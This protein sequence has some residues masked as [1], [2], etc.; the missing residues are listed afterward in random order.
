MLG[1]GAR[2][3]RPGGGAPGVTAPGAVS[4][5]P[6]IACGV[7]SAWMPLGAEQDA[8]AAGLGATGMAPSAELAALGVPAVP[9]TGFGALGI[10]AAPGSELAVPGAPGT[11]LGALV[12]GLPG[13]GDRLEG[14]AAPSPTSGSVGIPGAGAGIPAGLTNASRCPLVNLV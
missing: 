13:V 12:T 3:R 11:V 4:G 5:M 8:V 6:G 7:V 10:T 14:G 1:D 9:G 2:P